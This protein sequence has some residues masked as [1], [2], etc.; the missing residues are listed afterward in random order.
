MDYKKQAIIDHAKWAGKIEVTCRCPVATK[1][2]LSVAYTPGV[3]EPCLEIS[4]DVDLTKQAAYQKAGT[5]ALTIDPHKSTVHGEIHRPYKSHSSH[6]A[7][8]RHSRWN[9]EYS[10]HSDLQP[11]HLGH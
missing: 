9:T 4:K 5:V 2:D 1:D 3:A 11:I 10:G 6:I 8:F 7:P